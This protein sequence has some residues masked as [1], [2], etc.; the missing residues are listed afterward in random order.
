M[1]NYAKS[2]G[3]DPT[4]CDAIVNNVIDLQCL[5]NLELEKEYSI[6]NLSPQRG[7]QFVKN[8]MVKTSFWKQNQTKQK[9]HFFLYFILRFYRE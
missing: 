9:K 1:A 6:I 2:E 8:I 4:A 5:L 3:F 7:D